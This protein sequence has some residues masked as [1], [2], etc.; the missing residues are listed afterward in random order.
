MTTVVIADD[1]AM[2]RA[3]LRTI[4]EAAG[5]IDVVGECED[6]RLAVSLARTLTPDVV[7]MD[8][9]MPV[10]DGLEATRRIVASGSPS[11]ILVLTTYGLDEYV[12]EALRSGAAGFMVKTDPPELLIEAVR[13]VAAGEAMVGPATTR[14]LVER[15]LA[16]A[17]PSG[18]PPREHALLT[19][20]EREVLLLV[21]RGLSNREI[22]DELFV[23]TGT[24]K[25]HVAHILAK[26]GLR[27]RVQVVV[28]AYE[29]GIVRGGAA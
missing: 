15:F 3:G 9:R 29:H 10:V 17:P 4:L 26:L 21:A 27:D 24:V 2:V 19:E 18:D 14:A 7:V 13:V 11:R 22:A 16:G 6:G 1:Q 20:R 28:Y 23:G 5:D 12:Y 25:T 8:I